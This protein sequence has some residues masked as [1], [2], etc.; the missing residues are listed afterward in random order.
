MCMATITD[1]AL[2]GGRKIWLVSVKGKDLAC[3]QIK[4]VIL[5]PSL[6]L[7]SKSLIMGNEPCSLGSAAIISNQPAA[8]INLSR[9]IRW[10]L[11]LKQPYRVN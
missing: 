1:A 2:K 7:K 5:I 10:L 3:R 8:L 6:L 9:T 4:R 11:E